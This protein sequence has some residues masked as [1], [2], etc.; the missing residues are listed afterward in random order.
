[1]HGMLTTEQNH[2]LLCQY[3]Q[4]Y[5]CKKFCSI[6]KID[7]LMLYWVLCT[8]KVLVV[9]ANQRVR[10]LELTQERT[11]CEFHGYKNPETHNEVDEKPG[12]PKIKL[13]WAKN[14]FVPKNQKYYKLNLDPLNITNRK[15]E[16]C[17]DI[18]MLVIP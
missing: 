4:S 11:W 5:T 7:W 17:K 16:V 6:Q 1:M 9:D 12:K 14:N 3:Q 8:W 13:P 2:T 18:T 10:T 15:L